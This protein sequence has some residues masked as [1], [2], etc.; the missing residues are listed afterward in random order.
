MITSVVS[1]VEF[2][3]NDTLLSAT[4]VLPYSYNWNT[5]SVANGSYTLI[6]KAYDN[7]GNMGQSSNVS[8]KVLNDTTAPTITAF[9]MPATGSSTTVA[10]SSF[11]A[12]DDAS[13]TG[14]MITE[15][16]T[17][18]AASASGWTASAP[19]SFTFP[20]AG[21]KTAYAWA[22]DAA[23]NVSAV[24]LRHRYHYPSRYNRSG[25]KHLQSCHRHQRA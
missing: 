3:G 4:N 8:I 23:G 22:K 11:T 6:A 19:T 7:T 10:I 1:R 20:A 12:T 5:K 14:Y 17:A 9:T 13:V 2:Y 21:N 16:A 15:S 18:P 25:C 24:P